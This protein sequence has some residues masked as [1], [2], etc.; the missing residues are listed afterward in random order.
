MRLLD[1]QTAI[2]GFSLASTATNRRSISLYSHTAM[3][4]SPLAPARLDVEPN[5]LIT[6]VPQLAKDVDY[7]REIQ[8]AFK[9]EL[10]T[11]PTS[12]STPYIYQDAHGKTCHGH[13]IRTKGMSPESAVPGILFFHTGAG[14]HDV[15]LHWKADSLVTNS[16]VFPDGCVVLVT[17][18]LGDDAGWAWSPDRTKYNAARQEV[19]GI[20]NDGV[21]INLRVK[22]EAALKELKA[23]PG[24]DSTRL[25]AMGWCLGGHS[26]LEIARMKAESIQAMVTF[27]GVFDDIPPP[28]PADEGTSTENTC[29]IL[30]CNGTED[31]FVPESSLR[32]AM[33]TMKQHGH[34]VTLL[35]LKGAKHGFTSPAQDF[36][37][38]EA[39]GFNREGA[40][41]A[42][43]ST[44]E[45]LK[46]AM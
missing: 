20:D 10:R 3:D 39:F 33:D 27:H 29:R 14:P 24:V 8:I 42:W 41:E 45:L 1:L 12:E 26:I 31:P 4:W 17:D 18:I 13:L 22:I 11:Q 36:N 35:E 46:S 34:E 28:P 15:C 43:S 23:A 38:N 2:H 5:K 16:E 30:I 44:L 9:A 25:A 21:R 7:A 40:A 19:L 6:S 32:N 37:S